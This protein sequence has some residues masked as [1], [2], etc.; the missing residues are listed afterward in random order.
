MQT[1]LNYFTHNSDADY[2]SI[3]VFIESICIGILSFVPILH[4]ILCGLV[5]KTG[6]SK[7]GLMRNDGT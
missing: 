3:A 5:S 4:Y 1:Q 6:L 2:R 7:T